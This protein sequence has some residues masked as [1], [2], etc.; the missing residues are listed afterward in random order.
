LRSKA[1]S[2][3]KRREEALLLAK[4]MDAKLVQETG[5]APGVF[6]I[7]GGTLYETFL[8]GA[9]TI[10]MTVINSDDSHAD[11]FFPLSTDDVQ[12][13]WDVVVLN[14]EL[15]AEDETTYARYLLTRK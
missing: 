13:D 5:K 7:G 6:V 4:V 10:H 2:Y 9:S 15:V 12:K 14:E 11:V 3:L 1:P 8:G